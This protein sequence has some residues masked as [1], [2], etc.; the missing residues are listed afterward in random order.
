M[1]NAIFFCDIY[2]TYFY[3][4][5]NRKEL[6]KEFINNLI[7]LKIKDNINILYFCFITSDN[8][9]YLMDAVEDIRYHLP[10]DIILDNQYFNNG[11][12][13]LENNVQR[14]IDYDSKANI[15]IDYVS[16]IKEN[17]KIYK[18]YFADDYNL[19]HSLLNALNEK[20]GFNIISFEIGKSTELDDSFSSNDKGLKGLNYCL[21]KYNNEKEI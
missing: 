21:R 8:V 3:E 15:I 2:G 10:N 16:E 13:D 19:I 14:E 7:D 5:E 17:K 18:I 12:I 9:D 11:V 6:L 4:K 1:R 20:Y